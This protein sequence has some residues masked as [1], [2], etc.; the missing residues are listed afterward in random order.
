MA[1]IT[2]CRACKKSDLVEA[3]SLGDLAVSDFTDKLGDFEIAPLTLLL[4]QS[5]GLVQLSETVA[6]DTLYTHYHYKSGIQE[7]MVDA[8]DDVA[9][10][11]EAL[12]D[13]RP[14]DV[15]LDIGANDGTLFRKVPPSWEKIA[16]EPA[17]NLWAELKMSGAKIA[18]RY[19]P[20]HLE[21]AGIVGLNPKAKVI[22]SIACFYSVDDPDLFVQG[23]K[24][25]LAEDGV[26]VNQM[27]YFPETMAT[28]NFGDIC[29]EHVTYWSL[30]AF[31][32]LLEKHDL[33]IDRVEYN[34]IN[35]GSFRT[36][37]RHSRDLMDHVCLMSDK[38]T[39]VQL[40]RF[41]Q[42]IELQRSEVRSF[43][44]AAN[45][46]AEIVVGYGASTK[47]N[48]YLQYW[49]LDPD[50][51]PVL[52]DRNPEKIG[53]FV[54]T[55]QEVRPESEF[56]ESNAKYALVLP[57]HFID[58]FIEREREWLEAGGSFVVPFPSLSIIDK[59]DDRVLKAQPA[60]AVGG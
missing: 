25:C 3:L 28:N 23:I 54:P 47:G 57:Y 32:V 38:P 5:C 17:G 46:M 35:G 48:T 59:N 18:G 27:S 22:T 16:Y 26:W 43:V 24:K 2:A 29:H 44:H 20:Q 36:Y 6:R 21:H 51:V 53:K 41:R 58:S 49:G 50:M 13:H 9:R 39:L 12:V 45:R 52:I 7:S 31:C 10:S 60:S 15:W 40:K 19:F 30:A 4:C 42:R 11:A 56:R 33:T 1:A 55:G 37:V 8:L 34:G 14:G